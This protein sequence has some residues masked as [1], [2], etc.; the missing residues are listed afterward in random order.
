MIYT[1]PARRGLIPVLKSVLPACCRSLFWELGG[2]KNMNQKRLKELLHYCP[3]TGAFT[4]LTNRVKKDA[5]TVTS[6]G[7]VHL[8][9]DGV[10]YA[11]HRIVFLYCYGEWPEGAVDHINRV[12]HDNRLANLRLVSASQ[13]QQNRVLSK[14]NSSGH[15][16]VS[17]DRSRGKWAAA[18]YHASKC[19]HLGRFVNIEDAIAAYKVAAAKY[20]THNPAATL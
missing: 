8:W 18:I 2:V 17:W 7:Y 6:K 14:N 4:H 12:R 11:A 20:H 9:L 15:K 10:R 5:G 3:Y 1:D 16:G 13:N 19:K